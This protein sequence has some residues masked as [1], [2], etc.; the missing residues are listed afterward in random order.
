MGGTASS[1]TPRPQRFIPAAS[2]ASAR[3]PTFQPAPA[4][5]LTRHR[6]METSMGSWTQHQRG[7]FLN[8]E[9]P[10]LHTPADPEP[11]GLPTHLGRPSPDAT[12]H[13][14]RHPRGGQLF[15]RQFGDT[16]SSK[17]S[18]GELA[19]RRRPAARLISADVPLELDFRPANAA[20]QRRPA[21]STKPL[22]QRPQGKATA[23]QSSAI[24]T[25][26]R[27]GCAAWLNCAL[28]RSWSST[29]S[30]S[31][32]IAHFRNDRPDLITLF[33][34]DGSFSPAKVRGGSPPS[35]GCLRTFTVKERSNAYLLGCATAWPRCHP[36]S[37]LQA[38]RSSARQRLPES[39]GGAPERP[40]SLRGP[41][42]RRWGG[43]APKL[44]QKLGLNRRSQAPETTQGPL[45]LRKALPSSTCV[46]QRT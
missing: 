29:T 26:H 40:R 1:K 31:N 30:L 44:F 10:G 11:I 6:R 12:P 27:V 7:G 8:P 28:S 24:H 13:T 16:L 41:R 46:Q 15:D 9:L 23:A 43:G 39:P 2:C 20:A 38:A 3:Q 25:G 45:P 35:L 37:R 19:A 5:S 42:Q 33:R 17:A 14:P 18:S 21:A 22:H 4:F 34:V 32:L 36:E